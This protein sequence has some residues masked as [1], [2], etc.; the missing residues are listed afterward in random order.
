VPE[1]IQAAKITTEEAKHVLANHFKANKSSGLSNMPTQC[2]KW[3][4]EKALPT[5]VEFLNASAIEQLAP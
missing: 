4:G 3:M 1:D 2:L 5:L